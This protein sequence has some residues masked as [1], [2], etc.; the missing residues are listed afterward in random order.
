M[1]FA[2]V[3]LPTREVE[4]TAAFLE[5]AFGLTRIR[6]PD[7]SPVDLVWLDL[8]HGQQL[9]VF[10]VEGFEVSPFEQRIRPAHRA[11]SSRR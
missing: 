8:G 6:V 3:T 2:H 5:Q 7:N 11:L 10:Y 9:H 4:R 1:N